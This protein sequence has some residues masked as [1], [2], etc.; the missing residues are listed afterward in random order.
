MKRAGSDLLAEPAFEYIVLVLVYIQYTASGPVSASVSVYLS[1]RMDSCC[2]IVAG[3][4]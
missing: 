3:D 2:L 4:Y 1:L